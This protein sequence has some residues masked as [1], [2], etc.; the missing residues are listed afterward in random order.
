[1]GLKDN[2][3]NARGKMPSFRCHPHNFN[4]T[5]THSIGGK[6]VIALKAEWQKLLWIGKLNLL[7]FLCSLQLDVVN[8]VGDLLSDSAILGVDFFRPRSLD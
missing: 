3:L 7:S 2:G 8:K 1:M 5:L 6:I 4:C